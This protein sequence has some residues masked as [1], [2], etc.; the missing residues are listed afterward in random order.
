MTNNI[1]HQMRGRYAGYSSI[2]VSLTG[3]VAA[4]IAGFLI[5]RPFGAWRFSLL[6]GIGVVFGLL[7]V[8][9]A[10]HFPGGA[11]SVSK[12]SLFRFDTKVLA[13]LRDSR[14]VR[15]LMAL[16]LTTLAIGPIFSFLPIFMKERVGLNEGNIIFFAD[17]WVDRQLAFQLFLGLAG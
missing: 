15:Y 1:P 2:A 12:I 14:F 16:G 17:G 11:P 9:F 5:N 10:S 8:Y 4:A 7:S 6:Y 13:P 3:L